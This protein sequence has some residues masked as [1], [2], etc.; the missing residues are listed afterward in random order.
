MSWSEAGHMTQSY[1]AADAGGTTAVAASFRSPPRACCA[2]PGDTRCKYGLKKSSQ[3]KDCEGWNL[4][5]FYLLFSREQW[6]ER[7]RRKFRDD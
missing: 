6:A 2:T 7:C 5:K 1:E 4:T 3:E